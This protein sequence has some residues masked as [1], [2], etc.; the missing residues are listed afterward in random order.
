MYI[1]TLD[2]QHVTATS[3]NVSFLSHERHL[4]K[5]IIITY[6]KHYFADI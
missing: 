5:D 6:L 3:G 4:F 1:Y 2:A